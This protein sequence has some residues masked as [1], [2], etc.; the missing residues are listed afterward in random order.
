[1]G[2]R[3]SEVNWET[4]RFVVHSPKTER[5]G[6]SKRIVP[7]FNQLQPYLTEAWE[8][9]PE[10]EDRIFPEIHDKKSMGSWIHKLADRAGI[11]LWEKPFQNMRASCATDLADIYPGHVCEAWLGHTEKVANRHYRQVTEGHFAKASQI[12]STDNR[13][14]DITSFETSE[15]KK[16]ALQNR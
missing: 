11:A 14:V 16:N 7:I 13:S 1:M 5:K 10:G 9:A 2:L 4:G 3:W 8:T 6:K 15:S 12:G